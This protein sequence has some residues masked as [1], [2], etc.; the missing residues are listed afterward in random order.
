MRVNTMR[1]AGVLVFALGSFAGMAVL[2]C[3]SQS[4]PQAAGPG[5]IIK[6]VGTIKSISGSTL[7]LTPD[8]G[9]ET[10]VIVQEATRMVR[11]A[12]GQKDLKNASPIALGDLQ[13]GDRILVR[14][15]G[16]AGR[17]PLTAASIVV[18]KASDLEV[19]QQ[20]DREDWQR[21]GVG[22]LVNAVNPAAGTIV[23]ATGSFADK[24]I[25]TIHTD[26]QTVLRRYAPDSVKFDD[27]KP[28]TLA[29]IKVGDQLRARG[30]RSDDGKE[31]KADEIVSGTF[32]NIAGTVTSVDTNAGTITVVDAATKKPVIVKVTP[33][34]NA[35]NLPPEMGRRMAMRMAGG[36]AN[37]AGPSHE[38]PGQRPPEPASTHRGGDLQQIFGRLP[39]ITIAQ[40]Q[41]GDAVMIVSTQGDASGAV[42]AIS[43]LDGAEP[44]MAA[45]HKNG[46]GMNLSPW[47][48]GGQGGEEPA[49]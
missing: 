43:L 17:K 32:R 4:N 10:T 5:S 40:I 33:E 26:T 6:Q 29:D 11:I 45:A 18:M 24:S 34:S 36:P 9:P 7:I 12:P 8:S 21:R 22:G 46:E 2:T 38:S 49:Q 37:S 19:K 14:G 42:T 23:I 16:E 27:A 1:L 44:I 47:T 30:T 41:K 15:N 31:F 35:R 13:V 39:S 28:G 48:F 20:R 3:L 25:L